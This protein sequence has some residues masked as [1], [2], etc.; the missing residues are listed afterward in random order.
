[1][2]LAIDF[3]GTIHDNE[4]PIPGRKMGPPMFGAEDTLRY[5]HD[6]GYTIH[7]YTIWD[8]GKHHIIADWMDYYRIPWDLIT[9]RKQDADIY[10]DNKAVR[11]TSWAETLE[12]INNVFAYG[13]DVG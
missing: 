9:N 4:H 13:D 11:F 10:I 2:I 12:R 1:M 3:D 5:F 8:Q 7:V 6:L